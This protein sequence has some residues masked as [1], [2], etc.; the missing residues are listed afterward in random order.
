MDLIKKNRWLI[1]FSLL[2]GIFSLGYAAYVFGRGGIGYSESHGLSKELGKLLG[3]VGGWALAIVYARSALKI[4]I[5]QQTFWKRLD[6]VVPKELNLKKYSVKALVILNKTHAYAGTVAIAAIFLHCYLTGS[7]LDNLLLQI[8]LV[9][10]A[11][12]GISGFIMKLKYTP[13]QLKQK[14]YLIHRQF[15]IGAI[16]VIVT[17][18]GHLILEF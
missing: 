5:G 11:V 17:I 15:T 13:A 3:A 1:I 2:T 9:L 10:M 14:S 7:Y 6:P 8:V 12:E 18:V 4:M 16:L